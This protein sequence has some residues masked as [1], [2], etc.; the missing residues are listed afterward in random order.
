MYDRTILKRLHFWGLGIAK[1]EW[2]RGWIL[3]C[4]YTNLLILE[5]SGGET[6][7]LDSVYH[8]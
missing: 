2:V 4:L 7:C 3:S 1:L 8:L 5:I 6:K